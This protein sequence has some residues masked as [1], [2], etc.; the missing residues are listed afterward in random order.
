MFGMAHFSGLV[1]GGYVVP[2]TDS[3]GWFRIESVPLGETVLL[4]YPGV[5]VL[6]CL[7]ERRDGLGAS[8][9]APYKP[10]TS[11]PPAGKTTSP[12]EASATK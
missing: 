8:H 11:R 12:P 6:P 1:G 10:L 2:G 7:V 3:P 5:G 9:W 4:S